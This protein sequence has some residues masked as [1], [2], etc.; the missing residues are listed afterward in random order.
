MTPATRLALCV[1][2]F[3][4]SGGHGRG[5]KCGAIIRH[6]PCMVR[7]G[8]WN[9]HTLS[10]HSHSRIATAHATD[11]NQTTIVHTS[12]HGIIWHLSI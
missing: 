2:P 6:P 12:I 3:V 5:H 8:E 10:R 7:K 9:H 4:P 1:A 11:H